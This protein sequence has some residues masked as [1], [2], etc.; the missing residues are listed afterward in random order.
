MENVNKSMI[1]YAD[2]SLP[3]LEAIGLVLLVISG[4]MMMLE[5]QAQELLMIALCTLAITFFLKAH[6]PPAMKIKEG[7]PQGFTSLLSL[8][9]LPK[10]LWIGASATTIGIL[11][12]FLKLDGSEQ[13]LVIGGSTLA[14][15][16]VLLGALMVTGTEDLWT[17]YRPIL[18]RIVPV[19]MMAIYILMSSPAY[20][21]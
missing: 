19:L 15:G 1:S 6:R 2:K 7:E 20:K 16:T 5:M 12:Y 18:F 11:F 14:F 8:T 10:V 21:A 3:W 13:M 17:A 9:I 4:M